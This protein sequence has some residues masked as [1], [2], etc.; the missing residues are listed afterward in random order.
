MS[1]AADEYVEKLAR[2]TLNLAQEMKHL[3]WGVDTKIRFKAEVEIEALLAD[4]KTDADAALA[5][6]ATKEA[7]YAA[8]A[9]VVS[10]T[11]TAADKAL[12]ESVGRPDW[13]KGVPL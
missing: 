5:R 1:D 4:K 2:A 7:Y 10:R 9:R 6:A 13:L 3:I 12:I 11:A 8:L